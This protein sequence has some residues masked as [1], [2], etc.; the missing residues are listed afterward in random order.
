LRK[1]YTINW[2][3]WIN[4]CRKFRAHVLTLHFAVF[5]A[6]LMA[7]PS[8]LSNRNIA[9]DQL[10]QG[11]NLLQTSINCVLQDD[12][13]FLWVGTWS[14][15]IRYDGY[16]SVVYHSE[17]SPYKLKS[18]KIT[19]IYEDHNG[20][21]WI[22][23]QMEGLFRFDKTSEKFLQYKHNPHDSKSLSNNNVWCIR[24]DHRGN[25]WVGTENGLN[26][27][28][29]N[30]HGFKAFYNDPNNSQSITSSHIVDIFLSSKNE[31]FLATSHGLSMLTSNSKGDYT[32]ENYLYGDISNSYNVHN[33]MVKIA[34]GN[35]KGKSSI[36]IC[37][38]GGLKKFENKK[39]TNFTIKNK[40][41]SYNEFSS[42]Q[43]VD[44][45]QPYIL[46]G[47]MK[48]LNFFDP[49]SNTFTKFLTKDSAGTNLSHSSIAS[50]YFDRGGVL[51]VGT[52]KGINKYDTYSKKIETYKTS[53]FDESG[54]IVTGIQGSNNGSQ[55]ISTFGGGLYKFED[56]K[57]KVA[58]IRDS[59]DNDGKN[60]IQTLITTKDGSVWFGTA[61]DGIYHFNERDFNKSTGQ[62]DRFDHFRS[63]TTPA[64]SADFVMSL[65]ED[66]SGNIWVGTWNGGLNKIKRNG[67]IVVYNDSLLV[68]VPLVALYIDHSGIIWIGTRGNGLYKVKQKG[69]GIEIYD[70]KNTDETKG[71]LTSNFVSCIYEDINGLLWIG[72]EGGLHSFDLRSEIFR[73]FKSKEE[74]SFNAITSIQQDNIGKLWLAHAEGLT[75][76]DPR[77]NQYVKRFDYHDHV[78][79][80]FLYNSASYKD[81]I[82]RL[83]FGG[84]EGINIID[85]GSVSQNPNAPEVAIVDFKIFGKS[86]QYGNE[87]EGHH[88]LSKS[89]LK[90]EEI[91]LKSAENSISFEFTALDYAAPE[92]VRY[93]YML[94]GFDP[95]WNYT[96]FNRRYA[97]YT[98]L[99]EGNYT[100]KVKAA[101]SDGLWTEHIRKIK[102]TIAPPWWKTNWA[103]A[104]YLII[105]ITVVY[106]L[107]L[108]IL[109][110]ANLKHD[111]KLER[112]QRENL[113]K[114]NQSK[115]KFFTNISHEF[116]TPLTL[117][118][119]PVQNLLDRQWDNDVLNQL[120]G[121]NNNANRLLR[122]VNQLLDFRKAE[123]GNLK[124][125]VCEGNIV[126]FVYEIKLL[127]NGLAENLKIDFSFSNSS[128]SI[129]AWFDP[130]HLEKIMFNLLSNAFK[131]TPKGGK[132]MIDVFE[133]NDD[134]IIIVEDNGKGIKPEHF[135]N[136]FQAFFSYDDDK[137]HTGTGI[138]LAFTKSLVDMHH[139]KLDFES[140]PNE[141]TRFILKFRS[142]NSHFNP[143]ELLPASNDIEGME[144]APMLPALHNAKTVDS[145]VT[146]DRQT[147]LPNVL[148]VEDNHEVRDYIQSIFKN[149]YNIWQASNGQDGMELALDKMPDLIIS[150]VMMSIM[151]GIKLCSLLK[152]NVKTSHIPII[153]LTARTSLE[154]KLEGLQTGADDYITKPFNPNILKVKV[155]NIIH[156]REV[157]KK[158]F[159]DSKVLNIEP[160]KVTLTSIDE[161][162]IKRALDGVEQ[163]M[164][165]PNYNVDDLGKDVGISRTQLYIKIRALAGQSVNDFIRTIRLKRAAQLL[166]QNQL[167]IAEVTYRV[168]FTD[169]Q[170]FRD[171][172]KKFFGVIPSEYLKKLKEEN[173]KKED[174]SETMKSTDNSINTRV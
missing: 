151:D 34:E 150:D 55:W 124:L 136:I 144:H 100:F 138:G 17:N 160:G 122:L 119:G 48:G 110:R 30:L 53:T 93:A 97:V 89:L 19:T 154:F 114:L 31:F 172:F 25:L 45:I 168:G 77:D 173:Q 61:G 29:E 22:G 59:S 157:M 134:I 60:F 111:A 28:D 75:V 115:L 152:S 1:E 64:L 18:D 68:G 116:R 62:I 135:E 57:F 50:L 65:A 125:Q 78:Q 42:I 21:L 145:H 5:S 166:E 99:N 11:L 141:F 84:S 2:M 49:I 94:Q 147:V 121:I 90:T 23:T 148:I 163:N 16:T 117:I 130:D 15:L 79:G 38:L 76:I 88:V 95:D 153:L 56:Q 69:N 46:V 131:H 165:N 113:E 14:G 4:K 164:S 109:M 3:K 87:P 98:N 96:D 159:Q 143:S 26:V 43:V 101:N 66:S 120:T 105:V 58:S 123:S 8:T 156:M 80:G 67:E 74:F 73:L 9:F 91:T 108:L 103:I 140:K 107:R 169:L 127:F 39:F 37:T 133:D 158:M 71:N 82:G 52:R 92:K 170:H 162:L 81:E 139:G 126:K 155:R 51:W 146:H 10:P 104:A 118:L 27:F 6:F 24:E 132:I 72:T 129:K 70:V 7:Q 35:F 63:G 167:T 32:F 171:C 13:G 106:F 161:M 41:S 102:V 12:D 86:V 128:N 20:Y 36:W 83:F 149:D 137:H 85:P 174:Q 112:I 40:P 47:S 44:G 142:G 33:Y 54:N